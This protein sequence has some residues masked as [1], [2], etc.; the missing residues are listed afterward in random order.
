[1]SYGEEYGI[2][3]KSSELEMMKE[4]HELIKQDVSSCRLDALDLA[5]PRI[6]TPFRYELPRPSLHRKERRPPKVNIIGERLGQPKILNELSR[7]SAL[8]E[9]EKKR[10]AVCN[11]K[12]LH[13]SQSFFD[14]NRPVIT[15]LRGR[16][17][18][19]SRGL[20]CDGWYL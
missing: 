11:F 17:N 6:P 10:K 5:M 7:I 13:F 19:L 12:S 14:T 2:V 8:T 4:R 9:E 16:T 3:M 15:P 1:M 20:L 18:P